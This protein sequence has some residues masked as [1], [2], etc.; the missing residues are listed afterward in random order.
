MAKDRRATYTLINAAGNAALAIQAQVNILKALRTAF[1]TL[2]IDPTGTELAGQVTNVSNWI[3]A[4]D[5]EANGAVAT[6][7]VNAMKPTH[8]QDTIS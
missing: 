1:N 7:M 8:R 6:G 3:D 5:T 2:S 4:L